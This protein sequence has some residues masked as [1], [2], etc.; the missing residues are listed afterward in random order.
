MKT[1]KQQK[2]EFVAKKAQINAEYAEKKKIL[3]D[4]LV[5]GK[6][7]AAEHYRDVSNKGHRNLG[8]LAAARRKGWAAAKSE[9]RKRRSARKNG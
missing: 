5:E 4:Q 1:R 2:A 9:F 7:K 8:D 3:T 6:E